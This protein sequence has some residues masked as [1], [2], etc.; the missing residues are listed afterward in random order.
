MKN[1]VSRTEFYSR[2]P[3]FDWEFYRHMYPDIPIREERDAMKHYMNHGRKEK[4]KICPLCIADKSVEELDPSSWFKGQQ[5]YVSSSLGRFDPLFRKKFQCLPKTNDLH[6]CIF[7]GLYNDED[8]E[9]LSN[10]RGLRII[11]WGGEDIRYE[12]PFARDTERKVSLLRHV[13]HCAISDSI[14]SSLDKFGVPFLR[15]KLNLVDTTLFTSDIPREKQR[16][17]YIYNGNNPGREHIYG[18]SLYSQI[19]QRLP[20]YSYLMSN[21]LQVPYDQM[22]SIYAKCF[23]GLRLTLGHDGNANTV[24]ECEAMGI[25]IVHNESCY[26]LKWKNIQDIIL[27]IKTHDP[28]LNQSS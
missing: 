12:N 26:G 27:H 20:N 25:P 8:L 22:P 23:I 14:A 5:L 13:I 21:R 17:I 9:V 16:F 18:K 4:R 28:L 24:Q 3:S 1:D 10:H 2:F 7:F 11:I 19:M 6:P 15:I